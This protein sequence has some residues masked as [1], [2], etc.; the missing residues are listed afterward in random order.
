MKEKR[1]VKF[2]AY[3]RWESEDIRWELVAEVYVKGSNF[4]Y[5]ES[6]GLFYSSDSKAFADKAESFKNYLRAQPILIEKTEVEI[7]MVKH[8]TNKREE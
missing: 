8:K 6:L 2:I 1:A 3:P 4:S 7:D 5:T